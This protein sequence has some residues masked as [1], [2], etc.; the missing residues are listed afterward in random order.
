MSK[1]NAGLRIGWIL[2]IKT[3]ESLMQQFSRRVADTLILREYEPSV[4]N[5]TT[6]PLVTSY[7][8]C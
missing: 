4:T 3:F 8:T 5:L 6:P 7:P 2:L 1:T